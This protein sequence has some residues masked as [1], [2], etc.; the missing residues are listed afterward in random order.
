MTS[1]RQIRVWLT[2]SEP[3]IPILLFS[4]EASS[5]S[6]NRSAFKRRIVDVSL[7]ICTLKKWNDVCKL[8]VR[9]YVIAFNWIIVCNWILS[10]SIVTLD[11]IGGVRVWE[12]WGMRVFYWGYKGMR[13]LTVWGFWGYIFRFL[14]PNII[15]LC[16][17]IFNFAFTMIIGL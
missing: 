16:L 8:L 14:M 5:I 4:I 3:P 2:G 15:D 7:F 11:F 13:V 6:I 17:N 10:N 9:N 1:L 12:L